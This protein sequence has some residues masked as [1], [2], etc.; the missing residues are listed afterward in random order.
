MKLKERTLLPVTAFILIVTLLFMTACGAGNTD[1]GTTVQTESIATGDT[2]AQIEGDT[3][4]EIDAQTESI[5]ENSRHLTI[6]A[7]SDMHA[8]IVG[9]SYEDNTETEK[10]V[11]AR[12]YTYIQQRREENP[13]IVLVDDGDACDRSRNP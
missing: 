9:F 13:D 5:D 6:L 1:S 3:E 4:N 10:D 8:N 12:L 11:M 2:T 7:T